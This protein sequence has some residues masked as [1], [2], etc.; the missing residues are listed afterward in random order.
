MLCTVSREATRAASR[1]AVSYSQSGM[2]HLIFGIVYIES[3]SKLPVS[4]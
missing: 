1:S 2:G 4:L 3:E